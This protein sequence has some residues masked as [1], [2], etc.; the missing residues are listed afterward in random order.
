[1]KYHALFFLNVKK[2][3]TNL[4]SEAVEIGALRSISFLVPMEFSINQN[5]YNQVRMVNCVY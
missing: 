3:V 2:N 5:M 1:M 4:P